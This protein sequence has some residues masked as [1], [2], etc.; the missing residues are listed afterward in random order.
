M[1]HSR[2]GFADSANRPDNTQNKPEQDKK[3]V[4]RLLVRDQEAARGRIPSPKQ[5]V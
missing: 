5:T 1:E 2:C 4:Q 3:L